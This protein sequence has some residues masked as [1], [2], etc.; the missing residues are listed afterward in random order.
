M[1]KRYEQHSDLCGCSRCAAKADR[2]DHSPTFDIIDDP[3]Y[4]DCGRPIDLCD[5]SCE[6]DGDEE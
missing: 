1:G 5:R 2:D 6:D 3:S 4:C